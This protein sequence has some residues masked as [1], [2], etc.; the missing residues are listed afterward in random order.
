MLFSLLFNS[1]NW[2]LKTCSYY[3]SVIPGQNFLRLF[4]RILSAMKEND[5]AT[6]LGNVRLNQYKHAF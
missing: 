3:I 2:E 4:H 5:D 6:R 1:E